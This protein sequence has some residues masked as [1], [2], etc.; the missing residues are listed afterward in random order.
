MRTELLGTTYV[1]VVSSRS[2]WHLAY[3]VEDTYALF[4]KKEQ[5]LQ[6]WTGS[7]LSFLIAVRQLELHWATGNGW[8]RTAGCSRL[9][10]QEHAHSGNARWDRN[11]RGVTLVPSTSWR[12]IGPCTVLDSA[13]SNGPASYGPDHAC[14]DSCSRWWTAVLPFVR[15]QHENRVKIAISV[16][17][18]SEYFNALEQ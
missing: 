6:C 5:V 17:F 13:S 15:L 1:L 14:N 18:N 16:L 11:A 7:S 4:M 12:V 8:N 9:P 10:D 3:A 2:T